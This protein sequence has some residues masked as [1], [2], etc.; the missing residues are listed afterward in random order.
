M[1]V[2]RKL[3]MAFA[4]PLLTLNERRGRWTRAAGHR[5]DGPY[6]AGIMESGPA[7][8]GQVS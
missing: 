6:L 3:D 5:G 2:S 7:R 4:L 1:D 8:D